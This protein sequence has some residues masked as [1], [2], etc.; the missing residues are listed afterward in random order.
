MF[1]ALASVHGL[2][3]HQLDVK[4]T[5]IHG[6]LEEQIYMDQPEG[7]VASYGLKQAP[8]DWNKKFDDTVL[9]SDYIVN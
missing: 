1:V 4:T 2:I 5:F 8:R 7:F 3:I 6:D 9:I